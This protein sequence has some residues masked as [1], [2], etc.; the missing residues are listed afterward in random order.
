MGHKDNSQAFDAI[1]EA[2][3]QEESYGLTVGEMGALMTLSGVPMNDITMQLC[4]TMRAAYNLGYA[5]GRKNA[6][7]GGI[8]P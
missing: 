3:E 7:N 4:D 8:M 1:I 6:Q 5:R 2:M